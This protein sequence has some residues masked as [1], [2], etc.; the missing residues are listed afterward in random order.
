M[1]YERY[2][3]ICYHQDEKPVTEEEWRELQDQNYD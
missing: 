2:L 1:T 3:K